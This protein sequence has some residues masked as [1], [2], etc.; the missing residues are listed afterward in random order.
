MYIETITGHRGMYSATILRRNAVSLSFFP[1]P[2]HGR[3]WLTMT[4][5]DEARLVYDAGRYDYK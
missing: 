3:N 2:R 1:L 4:Q 5:A